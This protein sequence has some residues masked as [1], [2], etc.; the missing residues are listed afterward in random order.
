MKRFVCF[1][2]IIFMV[3]GISANSINAQSSH[4]VKSYMKKNGTY[5]SPYRKTKSDKSKFNNYSTKGNYNPYTGKKGT[6]NPYKK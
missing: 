1:I 3:V 6:K 5:V 4:R 2:S